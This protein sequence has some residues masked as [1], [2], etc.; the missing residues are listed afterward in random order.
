MVRSGVD[1]HIW[2]VRRSFWACIMLVMK[3]GKA[4]MWLQDRLCVGCVLPTTRVGLSRILW[5]SLVIW[6][7]LEVRVAWLVIGPSW[8]M[9]TKR[10]GSWWAIHATAFSVAMQA[11]SSILP[12]PCMSGRPPKGT[13]MKA[14]L[15]GGWSA[16]GVGAGGEGDHAKW[17]GWLVQRGWS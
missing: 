10:D 9:Y 5:R 15:M 1:Q 3:K 17:G 7:A 13:S 12:S 2:A 8:A 14:G 11:N 16:R 4:S 6:E